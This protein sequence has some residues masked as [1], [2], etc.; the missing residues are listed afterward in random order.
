MEN[1]KG[2][3]ERVQEI[4]NIL[5]KRYTSFT[6]KL[7][8]FQT[9]KED[10]LRKYESPDGSTT[11]ITKNY[12]DEP[13]V[14]R[15]SIV[16]NY[17]V[18][19]DSSNPDYAVEGYFTNDSFT[20]GFFQRT[21][22][23]KG[24]LFYEVKGGNVIGLAR[25]IEDSGVVTIGEYKNG[26]FNGVIK[27]IN[28]KS[29]IIGSLLEGKMSGVVE[30][31]MAQPDGS[32]A[33]FAG[34]TNEKGLISGEGIVDFP[35][36]IFKGIFVDGFPTEG[37]TTFKN[38]SAV[39]T[40]KVNKTGL[41]SGAGS[42]VTDNGTYTGNFTALGLQGVGTYVSSDS[43]AFY[44]G[45]FHDNNITGQGTIKVP[46]KNLSY[47]GGFLQGHYHG[48]GKFTSQFCTYEGEFISGAATGKGEMVLHPSSTVLKGTFN[49]WLI[50]GEGY[51]EGTD[52][53]G[54]K[55]IY[56]GHFQKGQWHGH[57]A[58]TYSD[59][60]WGWEGNWELGKRKGS[61][62]L[63]KGDPVDPEEWVQGDWEGDEIVRKTAGTGLGNQQVDNFTS[64]N[65]LAQTVII[66]TRI[67]SRSSI[68]LQFPTNKIFR[69]IV[70][71][72]KILLGIGMIMVLK[73]TLFEGSQ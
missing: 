68:N 24:N 12:G 5:G 6:E 39:F 44:E 54:K 60:K 46:S 20:D 22:G 16:N 38:R 27:S 15:R 26:A 43:E 47:T 55:F 11:F 49:N 10:D 36:Y 71:P 18:L 48:K 52:E 51:S 70:R 19:V 61:G 63:W 69:R 8:E 23:E 3:K 45:E 59:E 67:A 42:M 65:P 2:L 50:E 53:N 17:V 30:L 57:G 72:R 1:L 73:K 40:G 34:N 7:A 28:G 25:S 41:P 21:T 58:V 64:W 9:L 31:S 62:K 37:S 33:K 66:N 4:E 56:D 14:V 13:D 35:E 32:I 29:S